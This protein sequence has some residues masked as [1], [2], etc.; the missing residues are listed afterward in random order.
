MAAVG[1]GDIRLLRG[2][3]DAFFLE[4][5]FT[6]S[7]RQA[8]VPTADKKTLSIRLSPDWA[9]CGGYFAD[10]ETKPTR[11]RG[12]NIKLQQIS[13]KSGLQWQCGIFGALPLFAAA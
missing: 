9:I 10:F 8:V 12:E 7:G 5:P 2:G 6:A 13:R 3:D 11:M 4:Q 1:D